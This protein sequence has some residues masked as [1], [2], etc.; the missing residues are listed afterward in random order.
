M[1]KK[2][3]TIGPYTTFN[4][5]QTPYRIVSYICKGHNQVLRMYMLFLYL[6]VYPVFHT[7]HVS[8]KLNKI[9][10]IFL[11]NHMRMQILVLNIIIC[12]KINK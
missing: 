5:E 9:I 4:T 10:L 8:S 12:K 6:L 3:T 1:S 7:L 2:K 11:K